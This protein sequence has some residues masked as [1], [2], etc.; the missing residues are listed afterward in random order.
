MTRELQYL[1]IGENADLMKNFKSN[2]LKIQIN[3]NVQTKNFSSLE[4]HNKKITLGDSFRYLDL[5]E[6]VKSPIGIELDRK[7]ISRLID[8]KVIKVSGINLKKIKIGDYIITYEYFSQKKGAILTVV[9]PKRILPQKISRHSKV[10]TKIDLT[11][12]YHYAGMMNHRK[13]LKGDF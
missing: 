10:K 4:V 7:Q 5:I 12:Y 6:T 11:R 8:Q 13:N 2:F 3:S 1:A 9:S